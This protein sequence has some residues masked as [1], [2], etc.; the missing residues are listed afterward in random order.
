[1]TVGLRPGSKLIARAANPR[2]SAVAVLPGAARA[3]LGR[4]RLAGGRAP[5]VT[6][7]VAAAVTARGRR[8]RRARRRGRGGGDGG[9]RRGRAAALPS[10]PV[11]GGPRR[12]GG[13]DRQRRRQRRGRRQG[14]RRGRL[15]R[16]RAQLDGDGVFALVGRRCDR[17]PAHLGGRRLAHLLCRDRIAVVP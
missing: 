17:W 5:V 12:L 14:R 1:M 2:R 7:V 10:I 3:A 11:L 4:R 9:R 15:R 16:R 8:G 13:D 6:A